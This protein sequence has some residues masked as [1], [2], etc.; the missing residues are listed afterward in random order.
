MDCRT[1]SRSEVKTLGFLRAA[2]RLPGSATRQRCDSPARS[3]HRSDCRAGARRSATLR[4]TPPP[5]CWK[6]GVQNRWTPKNPVEHAQPLAAK[7]ML[8]N[9]PQTGR[10]RGGFKLMPMSLERAPLEPDDTATQHDWLAPIA[11]LI[12]WLAHLFE[13]SARLKRIRRTTKFKTNWRNHWRD[14]RS[15]N[16]C[17]TRYSPPAQHSCSWARFSISTPS[18]PQ[19]K[20]TNTM[21]ARVRR[22]RST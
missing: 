4:V 16:G 8:E 9:T 7:N 17:A 2:G 5:F 18:F 20:L 3:R 14:L 19:S 12:A 11:M 6:P 21:A 1:R 13:Q 22:R 15:T 10:A